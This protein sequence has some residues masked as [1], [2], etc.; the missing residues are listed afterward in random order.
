M[1]FKRNIAFIMEIVLIL[2]ALSACGSNISSPV[3]NWYN[4]KGKC[5]DIRQDGSW[6]L[7]D[8]YGTGT[9]KK[10]ND[11]IIEFTDF[12]GDTQESKINEDEL[13]KYIDFGYYGDFYKDAYPPE[14]KISEVKKQNA[15][16]INPFD[17]IKYEINGISPYCKLSINNQ[18]CTSE[19]QKYVTYNFDKDFYKNGE[20]ATITAVL[21]TNTGEET[22]VLSEENAK[23][24]I[25]EQ[26]EY[27]TS[28]EQPDIDALRK[29]ADDKINA[30]I[31]ASIG[32]DR[33]FGEDVRYNCL[34]KTDEWK[35][36][37]SQ[38]Y[39]TGELTIKNVT[40]EMNSV[41]F[42]LL[43]SQK[44]NQFSDEMPYNMISFLYCF[45]FS[46]DWNVNL[47]GSGEEVLHIPGKM[48]VNIIAKNIVKKQDGSIYWN[49]ERCD[50]NAF[51]SFDGIDNL[52]SNTI[53]SNSDN[54]NITKVEQY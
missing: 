13:G 46:T 22:Y 43:K 17:G 28:F 39:T 1:N 50:F 16:S 19:A 14:E 8:S 29:E 30:M 45:D 27:I 21:S 9:W 12:Y 5:L 53:M 41:Y 47:R 52:T 23:Y 51:I 10:L 35:A 48:Y 33:L 26:T 11:D 6:E 31:S 3:G 32:T 38:I 20:S 44:E 37:Q 24:K 4:E 7:E 2:Y 42:S 49:N 25:S 18:G 36:Y 34:E 54:Y 15:I 40:N